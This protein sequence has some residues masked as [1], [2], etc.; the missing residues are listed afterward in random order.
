MKR[1][2]LFCLF[3]ANALLAAPVGNPSA[4]E[5]IEKGFF[6]PEDGWGSVRIGYEG[7]FVSD[8]KLEQYSEGYGRVD[9]YEQETNSG[10]VTC[11]LWNR[12]DL[13]AV[14]GSS[15]ANADWRFVDPAQNVYRVEL[16]TN[17]DFLWGV[18]V[19]GILYEDEEIC[20]DMGGR[21]E[22]S[23]CEPS[24]LASNGVPQPVAHSMLYWR[25]WQIDL[26]LSYQIDIFAPYIGV[27]Y[28]NVRV[29]LSNFSEPISAKGGS[30][31]FKNRIP[32]GIFIGCGLSSSKYFLLNI[33]G[34]LI[35]E[36]A[37][38]VSGDIRF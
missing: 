3:F 8:A 35:D 36:T 18:G 14:L 22:Q 38:T 16:E 1:F 10:T 27:K 15:R 26:D 33:E 2:V 9:S 29:E 25:E 13:F 19:R 7:D 28:S 24:W 23:S 34:R 20:L 5:W 30:D 12:L 32:L 4:P 17:Y 6:I 37:V 11:N 21:F 31:H